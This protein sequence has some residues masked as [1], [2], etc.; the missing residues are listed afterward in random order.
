MPLG[1]AIL[2]FFGFEFLVALTIQ[3]LET[4]FFPAIVSAGIVY[5][6][7]ANKEQKIHELLDS[8]S[9]ETYDLPVG[10]AYAVIKK[11]LRTF[12]HKERD[13]KIIHDEKSNYSI[14]A[15]SQWRD[16]S[17]KDH[18]IVAPDGYLTRQMILQI[19]LRRNS[20]TR[21]A[22]LG[23]KWTMV[24][25]LGR[26]ECDEFQAYTT[27]AIRSALKDLASGEVKFADGGV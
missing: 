26:A 22:E 8:P 14:T 11:T 19:A 20:Q 1:I 16:H 15:K 23:M 3:N 25:P 21:L 6:L 5:W 27:A 24:S 7:A 13:W 12:S 18:K 4:G 2:T 10:Q 9:I 17:M